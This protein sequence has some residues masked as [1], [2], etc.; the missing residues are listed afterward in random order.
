MRIIKNKPFEKVLLFYVSLLTLLMIFVSVIFLFYLRHSVSRNFGD[1]YIDVQMLSIPKRAIIIP[2]DDFQR[3][4]VSGTK[5]ER[6][7][8]KSIRDAFVFLVVFQV[9]MMALLCLGVYNTYKK[10]VKKPLDEL[11]HYFEKW[12]QSEES[13]FQVPGNFQRLKAAFADFEKRVNQV[14]ADFRHLG[15]YVSHEYKNAMALLRAKIQNGNTES[16]LPAIDS[17]VKDMDDILTL[18]THKNECSPQKLDLALVC[19]KAAD[20]FS[21]VHNRIV[22][23]FDEE[24]EVSVWG[25]ELWIYR[26]VCNLLDNAVKYGGGKAIDV[27]VGVCH[28][29]PFLEVWDHGEGIEPDEREKIFGDGYRIAAVKKDGYG[30]GLSLV[31]HVAWLSDA[32]LWVKSERGKGTCFKMVFPPG[33]KE[34]S[35]NN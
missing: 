3:Y 29:C 32:Y 18:C 13:N 24:K 7:F 31:K 35:A 16:L 21:K 5:I 2:T 28:E 4:L 1:C 6:I 12:E 34:V 11:A 14:Y 17:L 27:V 8:L 33:I 9:A 23:T 26:A 10:I 15:A 25:N 19:G 20:E 30:I 22:F